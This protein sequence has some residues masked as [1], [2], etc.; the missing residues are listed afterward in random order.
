MRRAIYTRGPVKLQRELAEAHIATNH[1]VC[2]P[3][4]YDDGDDPDRPALERLLAD[5]GKIDCVVV[6]GVDR[7]ARRP[8]D[9]AR[10]LQIFKN[11][12]TSLV[13][14]TQGKCL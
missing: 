11:H 10:I 2:L 5:V 13:S 7:L 3:D 12:S 14:A 9:L 4:R 6:Y 8:A 1:W